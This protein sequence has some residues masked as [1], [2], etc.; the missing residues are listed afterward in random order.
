MHKTL[1]I[2]AVALVCFAAAKGSGQ[3][4]WRNS[5]EATNAWTVISGGNVDEVRAA[6]EA[7]DEFVKVR[8]A[9]GRGPLWWAYEYGQPEIVKVLIA[10]GAST[11]ERDADDKTPEQVTSV[12]PTDA[13]VDSDAAED[14][15]Y[16][17]QQAAYDADPDA[18]ADASPDA[19]SDADDF[20]DDE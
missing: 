10:A 15:A 8:A 1:L 6:V 19:S 13:A 4:T 20:D 12:G 11:T 18:S 9:D 16:E 3:N 7:S 17:A 14:A 2:A 5:A